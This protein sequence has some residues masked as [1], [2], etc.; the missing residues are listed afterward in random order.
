VGIAQE[1]TIPVTEREETRGV[2]SAAQSA[3]GAARIRAARA[4][5]RQD[6]VAR[7]TVG[8]TGKTGDR[9]DVSGYVRLGCFLLVARFARVIALAGWRTAK[10]CGFG[11]AWQRAA[12]HSRDGC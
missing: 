10:L 9:R 4:E 5:S 12:I 3:T 1:Y 2:D 11:T 8:L 6:I 7:H